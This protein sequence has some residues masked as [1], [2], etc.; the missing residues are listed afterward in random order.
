MKTRAAV[1]H[2]PGR[3]VVEELEH[4]LLL[5]PD[6]GRERERSGVADQLDDTALAHRVESEL[7]RDQSVPKGRLNINVEFA[8]PDDFIPELPGW[9]ERSRFIVRE[10]S[11]DY[12][13]YDFYAQCLAKIERG[14]IV[15]AVSATVATSSCAARI[16]ALCTADAPLSGQVTNAVPS[17]AASAPNA[18]SSPRSTIRT[19]RACWTAA[20]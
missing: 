14:E 6:A 1:M 12:F 9:Q 15:S 10:H 7:F 17:C 20:R 19:S 11:L 4:L 2:E 5:D 3:V 8:S 18:A 13:H 16:A